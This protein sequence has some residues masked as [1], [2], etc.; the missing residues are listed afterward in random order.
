MGEVETTGGVRLDGDKIDRMG[1]HAR[2]GL[3]KSCH[4]MAAKGVQF[5]WRQ[6]SGTIST[7]LD[8]IWEMS[9]DWP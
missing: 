7:D 3:P 8:G 4:R 5:P 1:F 2:A 9:V 6:G